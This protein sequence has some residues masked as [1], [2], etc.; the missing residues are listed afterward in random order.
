[1]GFLKCLS[2]TLRVISQGHKCLRC[3]F[4][5]QSLAHDDELSKFSIAFLI[6]RAFVRSFIH[7]FFI[8]EPNTITIAHFK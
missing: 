3:S 2:L 4:Q 5:L 6:F 1:M 8:L 7:T